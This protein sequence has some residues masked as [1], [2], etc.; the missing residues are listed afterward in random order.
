MVNED[1][2]CEGDAQWGVVGS[3]IGPISFI[4][5]VVLVYNPDYKQPTETTI[6]KLPKANAV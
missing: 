1:C 4:D 6:D 2:C 3:N 5:S